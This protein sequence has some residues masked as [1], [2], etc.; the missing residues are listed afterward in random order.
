MKYSL[1]LLMGLLAGVGELRADVPRPWQMHFQEAVTPVMEEIV[2][3]H[4]IL[5]V[6]IVLIG[7]FVFA[8]L[9]YTLVRFRAERNPVPTKTSHNTPLEIVWTAIPVLILLAICWP[10]MHLLYFMDR[11][12]HPDMTLKINGR[13]W[14]W[15]YAYE[16]HDLE[17]DSVMIPEK[18]LQPGQHR[19]LEVDHPV[20]IPVDTTVRL[21]F[22][23]DDV[24]HSWAVPAFGV[25]QD[26]VPGRIAESWVRVT[27]EGTY[28]GQCSE[29]C[30]TGH[31]FMPIK[32]QVVS[33]EAYAT[34]LKEAK[35]K[36]ASTEGTPDASVILAALPSNL[37]RG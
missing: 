20:V 34:W 10:S 2:R 8:L 31:A 9:G 6:L 1:T 15:H 4:D 26:T 3:F 29:L 16:G 17:F 27:K 14:Y 7:L 19:L 13:Q 23:A 32:V 21:L 22:T 18:D 28:Y 35:Q 33:K 24:L 25:K 37:Q 5:L 11:A 12:V 36:L 30:G